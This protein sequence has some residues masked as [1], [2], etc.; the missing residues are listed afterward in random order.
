MVAGMTVNLEN[1]R[2]E[3]KRAE[4]ECAE[5]F[6]TA[7]KTK[8]DVLAS[9]VNPFGAS[10]QEKEA[11]TKI[12]EAYKPYDSRKQEVSELRSKLDR[13]MEI[14]G[15]GSGAS[16]GSARPFAG[17]EAP[18]GRRV[19][20]GSRFA[21]SEQYKAMA[22]SGAFSSESALASA[23]QRGFD[24]PVEIVSQDELESLLANWN[25][26]GFNATTVTGGGA[27]SAHPFILPDLVPGFVEYRRKRP[28]IAGLVA[29]GSTTSDVVDYVLQSAPTDNAAETAEDT[30]A[31]E[32]AYA[33]S[34]QATNV[35]EIT[36]SVPVT[37]RAMADYGQIRTII[38]TQLT[39]GA[40]DRQ[41]T[42]LATGDGAGQNLLGI[43]NTGGIGTKSAAGKNKSEAI[44][45]GITSIRIAPGV[46]SE[47]D[48]V[49]LHPNDFEKLILEQDADGRYIFGPPSMSE[50]RAIWGVPLQPSI[51]FTSGTPLVGDF[52]GSAILWLR[53]ALTVNAG[54]D[55]NDF[56]KRRMTL[57]AAIRLAFAVTRPG[58]F[59]TITGF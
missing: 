9:G 4:A 36:H 11:F 33:F 30:Q 5:L 6:A 52:Y 8:A 38:D 13:M 51:V 57:L 35:R 54:L 1:V 39:R 58:G 29:V 27:T 25:N 22:K 14:E 18:R 17:S 47:P 16:G 45:N 55:G 41:D 46:L 26:P 32:S 28:L 23:M 49:G 44:H 20:A 21:D 19:T 24:R 31:P 50:N 37:L 53:E 7:E 42:Q 59:C 56:T 43:Y 3:L 10:T 2:G 40:L 12:D 48:N 15:V 34:Q